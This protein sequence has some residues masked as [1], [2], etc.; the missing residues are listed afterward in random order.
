MFKKIAIFS[1]ILA[2]IFY[3]ILH[4]DKQPIE[5]VSEEKTANNEAQ[6][7]TQETVAVGELGLPQS[8]ILSLDEI[9]EKLDDIA[10]QIDILTQEIKELSFLKQ[11]AGAET[12]LSFASSTEPIEDE[13]EIDEEI[14]EE[15]IEQDELEENEEIPIVQ[16]PAQKLCQIEPG[17]FPE[18]N[19]VMINELAWMGSMA[20][21]DNEWLEIKNVFGAEIS[22]SGWQIISGDGKIK[23]FFSKE[24]F[25]PAFA[26]YL[27]ERTDDETLPGL[28]ADKIYTGALK[29]DGGSLYLF[30]ENCQ[31][32]DEVLA[33]S[34]WPFGD[35]NSK[36]TMERRGDFSW[37]TSANAGG[38]PKAENSAGFYEVFHSD[39]GGVVEIPPKPVYLKILISEIQ[40]AGEES[41]KD[42]FVELYNPNYKDI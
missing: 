9:Q 20:S 22:L 15:E 19:K 39:G 36:R 8:E 5:N 31:L 25:L 7:L 21:A 34:D 18:R 41:E 23:I 3:F 40:I 35:N 2:A 4:K 10:E 42:D 17:V 14:I 37:Q 27:L 1:F 12:E 30:N 28:V 11:V 24:D 13:E 33:V 29:N 26:F 32:Q 38:T 6:Y 16:P